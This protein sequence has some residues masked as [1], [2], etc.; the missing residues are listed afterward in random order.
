MS[1][2]VLLAPWKSEP[3]SWENGVNVNESKGARL[4]TQSWLNV[5]ESRKDPEREGGREEKR[6]TQEG[7]HAWKEFYFRT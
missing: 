4:G 1:P 5:L 2:R 6:G 7:V 3:R